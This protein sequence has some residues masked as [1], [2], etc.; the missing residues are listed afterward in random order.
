M[1]RLSLVPSCPTSSRTC[2]AESSPAIRRVGGNK[3]IHASRAPGTWC[4]AE[5]GRHH[6]GI[7]DVVQISRRA[8]EAVG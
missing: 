5:L 6:Q 4:F 2:K 7:Y 1:K 8:A 3:S